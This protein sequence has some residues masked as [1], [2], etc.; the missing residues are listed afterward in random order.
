MKCRRCW[1]EKAYRHRQPG[2]KARLLACLG[3]VS[4]KCHHCYHKF[5][6]FWFFTLGQTLMPP[7]KN[8]Q[9][10]VKEVRTPAR[11]MVV[12][13]TGVTPRT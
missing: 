10:A 9:P 13:E 5:H 11:A 4:L 1:T 3:M 2:V 7:R 6:I 8:S 12:P